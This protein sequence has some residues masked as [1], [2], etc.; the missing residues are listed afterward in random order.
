MKAIRIL[1]FRFTELTLASSLGRI[2]VRVERASGDGLESAVQISGAAKVALNLPASGTR[3]RPGTDWQDFVD[4]QVVSFRNRLRDAG[5]DLF[6]VCGFRTAA[7]L[8]DNQQ[9]FK[10]V[11]LNRKSRGAGGSQ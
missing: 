2:L 8:L 3:N 4:L 9:P 6:Q 5:D 1:Q 7:N 10:A 11:A